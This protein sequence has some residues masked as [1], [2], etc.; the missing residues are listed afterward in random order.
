MNMIILTDDDLIEDN[1]FR[2]SG[3]RAKH[4]LEVQKARPGETLTAGR[5]GGATGR[6]E[7][8]ATGPDWVELRARLDDA[9]P[10][11]SPVTLVLALPRPKWL[12]RIIRCVTTLGVKRL[13]LINAFRV[14]KSYWNSPALK[15]E[16]LK[17]EVIVGLEQAKDT[18]VPE[19]ILKR[20]FKPFV[21]DELSD[22]TVD[23]AKFVAHPGVDRS[24]PAD[25]PGSITLAVG[26]EGGFIQY[27]IDALAERDFQPVSLGVRI[28]TVEQAIPALVGR[29]VPPVGN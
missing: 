22:A 27:E 28:L 19:I 14:D 6:A 11:P 5:F 20:R 8:L 17:R 12:R 16:S 26:P 24:C 7:V 18:V 23:S 3:P 15:T 13:F 4:V 29:L 25:H 2:L 1:R 9:P 21:E 10:P